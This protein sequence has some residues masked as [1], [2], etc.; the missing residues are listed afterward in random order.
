MINSAQYIYLIKCD[1]KIVKLPLSFVTRRDN[2]KRLSGLLHFDSAK[3]FTHCKKYD[4]VSSIKGSLPVSVHMFICNRCTAFFAI[5]HARARAQAR[6]WWTRWTRWCNDKR[7]C[8]YLMQHEYYTSCSHLCFK[9]SDFV[10]ITKFAQH[11]LCYTNLT[12][13]MLST[14]RGPSVVRVVALWAKFLSQLR[15]IDVCKFYSSFKLC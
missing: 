7:L 11:V 3:S 12:L 4:P 10:L 1:K 15:Q 9:N 6:T 8:V 2:H 5:T 14:P 13:L